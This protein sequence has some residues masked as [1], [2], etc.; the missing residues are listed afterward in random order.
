MKILLDPIYSAR[1]SH[2]SSALKCWRM[3]DYV[4]NTMKRE[5]VFFRWLIPDWTPSEDMDWF[6]QHPN[7]ELIKYPYSKD[8][9]AEY[10]RFPHE[11]DRLVAFDGTLWDTDV[12]VTMR[13]Q[14]VPNIKIVQTSPR[15]YSQTF[16]KKC[17][18]FEEMP[19][20]G[21]KKT[22]ATSDR[23][24]QDLATTS[25]ALAADKVFITIQHEKDG[26]INGAK[27]Y[28]AP[29]AILRLRENIEV[30]SPVRIDDYGF[31][32]KPA[33]HRFERGK[34]PLCLGFVG[35]MANTAPR[36]ET[37][38]E[39][40]E[41]QWVLKG[42]ERFEVFISTVTTGIKK[43]P[44]HFCQLHHLPRAEFWQA[45]KTKMDLVLC[46]SMDAG[47]GMSFFE[48]LLFGTPMVIAREP[49]TEALIG[50]DYPFFVKGMT[51]AYAMVNLW[52][53]NYPAM[54]EQFAAWQQTKLKARFEPG[55][56]YEHNLY[57]RLYAAI[58]QHQETA[59]ERFRAQ[60]PGKAENTIVK[61]IQK[62]AGDR[63]EIV[64]HEVLKEL[65]EAGEFRQ[66]AD[67]LDD[68]RGDRSIVWAT[69]WNDF[70]TSLLAFHGWQ[71][72]S[73]KVGHLKRAPV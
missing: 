38:Y 4:L 30:V 3:V 8:R 11:Y 68:Q 33:E 60:Y 45:I 49:W 19:V 51:E 9:M 67:K 5:D 23:W 35:R 54:Y 10:Q 27:Q 73:T 39:V 65:A 1:P 46:L 57:D 42:D 32:L 28:F 29:S 44:P 34:R 24:V 18:V 50:K 26:I 20:M 52:H 48:P 71:D 69:P 17:I 43:K 6:P 40:M 41:K 14:Q 53:E 7:L 55:G 12:V 58:G 16:L 59:L 72:A 62:Q 15:N 56:Q 61:A 31:S 25:G 21:F 64:I 63:Q 70:R 66:F 36:L 13:T 2:C 22:V 37:V 47:F